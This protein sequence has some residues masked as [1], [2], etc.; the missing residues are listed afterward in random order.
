MDVRVTYRVYEIRRIKN[1]TLRD[2]SI[3][4]GISRTE[5]NNIENNLKDPTIRTMCL[6]SLALDVSLQ[7]LFS[8][9]V[10]P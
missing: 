5:I 1:M 7:D 8:I 6:L 9:E 10:I 2:L 4:S 3:K